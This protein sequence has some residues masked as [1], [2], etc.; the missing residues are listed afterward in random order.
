MV[1]L[2]VKCLPHKYK[3]L[4]LRPYNVK[5]KKA[6]L[7]SVCVPVIIVIGHLQDS[8]TSQPSILEEL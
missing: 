5:K 3:D 8:M 6:S 1:L 2:L 4:S 7:G